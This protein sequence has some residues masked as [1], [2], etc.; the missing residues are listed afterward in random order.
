MTT[1]INTTTAST[2]KDIKAAAAALG[3]NHSNVKVACP[4]NCSKLRCA[5]LKFNKGNVILVAC[6]CGYRR[7]TIADGNTS[8]IDKRNAVVIPLPTAKA[9]AKRT[10]KSKAKEMVVADATMGKPLNM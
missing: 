10:N 3:F 1:Y 5:A 9:K 7:K 8:V 4:M 6:S 2:D